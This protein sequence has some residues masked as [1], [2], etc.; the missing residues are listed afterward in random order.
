MTSPHVL[1]LSKGKMVDFRFERALSYQTYEGA[2]RLLPMMAGLP[3][4]SI[5]IGRLPSR[6]RTVA[7]TG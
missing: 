4:T 3:C 1:A 5:A 7:S 6:L 2:L